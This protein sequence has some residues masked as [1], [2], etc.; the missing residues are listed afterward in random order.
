MD[1]FLAKRSPWAER[2]AATAVLSAQRRHWA[3]SKPALMCELLFQ[4]DLGRRGKLL[5]S[6]SP[7][8][9]SG[10]RR[11]AGDKFQRKA[12]LNHFVLIT[13]LRHA[14]HHVRLSEGTLSS[15]FNALSGPRYHSGGPQR[16]ARRNEHP[17]HRSA[18]DSWHFPPGTL[19]LNFLRWRHREGFS[20]NL[21]AR[22]P[23]GFL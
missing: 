20:I 10:T 17:A 14:L 19:L 23:R 7:V 8:T 2:R 18:L 9:W 15:A 3:V 4:K 13:G 11:G 22:R 1:T 21:S 16:A 5:F 12:L 6:K